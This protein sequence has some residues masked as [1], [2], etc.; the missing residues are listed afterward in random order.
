[1]QRKDDK[2]VYSKLLSQISLIFLRVLPSGSPRHLISVL[3]AF[4]LSFPKEWA[5]T[6]K[7]TVLTQKEMN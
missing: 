3:F 1:M 5:N 4:E 2:G 7:L 6:P